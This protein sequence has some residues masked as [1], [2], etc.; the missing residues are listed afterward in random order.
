MSAES[1]Q[2][3]RQHIKDGDWVAIENPVSTGPVIV[4]RCCTETPADA[5]YVPLPEPAGAMSFSRTTGGHFVGFGLTSGYRIRKPTDDEMST[6]LRSG[7]RW[8]ETL[9]RWE[10]IPALQIKG[11][12]FLG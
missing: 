2:E 7:Q 4:W 11:I 5:L 10:D 1:E 3:W 8:N 9:N 6:V 12:V